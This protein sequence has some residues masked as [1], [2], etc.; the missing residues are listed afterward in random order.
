MAAVGRFVPRR[1]QWPAE[2]LVNT[3]RSVATTRV[4]LLVISAALA[5]ASG[6]ESEAAG[7]PLTS[8]QVVPPSVV[9]QTW[10]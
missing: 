4:P 1:A 2:V 6:K 3:P 9:F 10:P 8:V 5:G 7:S